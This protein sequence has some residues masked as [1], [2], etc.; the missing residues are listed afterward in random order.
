MFHSNAYQNRKKISCLNCRR[1]HTKCEGSRPCR[2]CISLGK[3]ETCHDPPAKLLTHENVHVQRPQAVQQ[4]EEPKTSWWGLKGETLVLLSCTPNF[5]NF[6]QCRPEE[7][8]QTLKITDLFLPSVHQTLSLL[9]Q[10]TF[11]SSS[12]EV[13][14][15]QILTRMGIKKRVR[16]SLHALSPSSQAPPESSHLR[17]FEITFVEWPQ[18]FPVQNPL[19]QSLSKN[20]EV[21][22]PRSSDGFQSARDGIPQRLFPARSS[23]SQDDPMSGVR[24]RMSVRSLLN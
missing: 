17:V 8:V 9:V 20:M 6:I 2:R 10:R 14:D 22:N 18:S 23:D 19:A 13:A 3:P 24:A 11:V 5:A 7:V 1:S 15:L 21:D 12:I 16:C 4:V